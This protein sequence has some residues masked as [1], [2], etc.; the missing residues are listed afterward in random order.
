MISLWTSFPLSRG[1]ERESVLIRSRP[2]LSELV[3]LNT[4]TTIQYVASPMLQFPNQ[5]SS[6]LC[7]K[8]QHYHGGGQFRRQR[9]RRTGYS[10][11][12]TLSTARSCCMQALITVP[13]GKS[14]TAVYLCVNCSG[15]HLLYVALT[16]ALSAGR[17]AKY[18]SSATL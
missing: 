17:G 16:S 15:S 7:P 18:Y 6:C 14:Y 11:Q 3:K 1:T 2:G 5:A 13:T 8:A 9:R 4:H 12:S 10:K